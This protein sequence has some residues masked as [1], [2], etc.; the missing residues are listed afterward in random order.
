MWTVV[1]FSATHFDEAELASNELDKEAA[2][3]RRQDRR[4]RARGEG[5]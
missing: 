1:N 3:I 2:A 4:R 5:K